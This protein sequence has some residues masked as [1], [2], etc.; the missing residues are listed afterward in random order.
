[1]AS[2]RDRALTPQAATRSRYEARCDTS[3]PSSAL[4]IVGWWLACGGSS[5]PS[6][7]TVDTVRDAAVVLSPNVVRVAVDR[8]GAVWA[9]GNRMGLT[10]R[11]ADGRV[12]H[13]TPRDGLP[14]AR[15]RSIAAAPDGS[16]W[17]STGYALA[18]YVPA[19]RRIVRPT[20]V[21]MPGSFAAVGNDAAG[22]VVLAVQ[23]YGVARVD[24][25][26]LL[27]I[28]GPEVLPPTN[29]WVAVV[30]DEP[31]TVWVATTG[32]G[33]WRSSAGWATEMP[34]VPVRSLALGPDG[35][36][37]I[38]T[39]GAGLWRAEPDADPAPVA[40]DRHLPR[41]LWDVAFDAAGGLWVASEWDGLRYVPDP[42]AAGPVHA[43]DP[44]LPVPDTL[45]LAHD[46]TTLWVGH[47]AGM[48]AVEEGAS[49]LVL[50][51][52]HGIGGNVM[53]LH[54]TP[55]GV[56]A[57]TAGG[58]LLA[59]N[60]HGIAQAGRREGVASNELWGVTT[61]RSETNHVLAWAASRFGASRAVRGRAHHVRVPLG[62]P[63]NPELYAIA[64]DPAHG[65]VW[66]ASR[67]QLHRV[68]TRTAA[69]R[70]L[71]DRC[72]LPSRPTAL[73]VGDEAL[74]VG[75]TGNERNLLEVPLAEPCA[76]S[77]HAV[78]GS[79]AR[80]VVDPD[81][82]VL[83]VTSSGLYH[84]RK[85]ARHAELRDERAR[86]VLDYDPSTGVVWT[87][88]KG[89]L[90]QLKWPS[91]QAHP[92]SLPTA[93]A[94]ST[95]AVAPT[96]VFVSLG[97]TIAWVRDQGHG[98]R[99]TMIRGNTE[100]PSVVAK[101]GPWMVQSRP[102]ALSLADLDRPGEGRV[103]PLPG[104]Q[105]TSLAP[106][107]DHTVLV[108]S[109]LSGLLVM[110]LDTGATW[111]PSRIAGTVRSTLRA[112]GAAWVAMDEGLYRFASIEPD[113][114]AAVLVDPR[115]WSALVEAA[116]G[117]I[118]TDAERVEA[119]DLDGH[120][121]GVVEP[122]QRGLMHR[123]TRWHL[124][125]APTRLVAE[126]AHPLPGWAG[127]RREV[128]LTTCGGSE[129]IAHDDHLVVASACG[130]S[131]VEATPPPWRWSDLL[132]G[133]AL[134]LLPL[135]AL[136]W[137]RRPDVDYRR[138]PESLRQLSGEAQFGILRGLA[139]RDELAAVLDGLGLPPSRR[140]QAEAL[141]G[142][143]SFG[144]DHLEVLSDLLEA[145][146]TARAEGEGGSGQRVE[147]TRPGGASLEIVLLALDQRRLVAETARGRAELIRSLTAP[148][149]LD[150]DD[151]HT[152]RLAVSQR[153]NRIRELW[154]DPA[155]G[156]LTRRHLGPLLLSA[157]PASS[158]AG[159][160]VRRG[161]ARHLSPYATTGAVKSADMFY[162][163]TDV[164]RTL[165]AGRHPTM[166]L[167]GPRRVGKSS[168]LAQL[169]RLREPRPGRVVRLHLQGIERIDDLTVLLERAGGSPLEA[170]ELEPLLLQWLEEGPLTLLLDEA[171]GLVAGPDGETLMALL[172]RTT[173]N[174]PL[175]VVLSGYL[176]LYLTALDRRGAA[177][178]F[179]DIVELGPLDAE[180]ALELAVEPLA[181][182]GMR[183]S[184]EAVAHTLVERAGRYPYVVQL[185]CDEALR[186]ATEDS[187]PVLDEGH[188]E[189]ACRSTRVR[190]DFAWFVFRSTPVLT[191]WIC[192]RFCQVEGLQRSELV[193]T[194]AAETAADPGAI[195]DAL[196]PLLLFGYLRR[197]D[198][199]EW[200]WCVPLFCDILAADAGRQRTLA[201]LVTQLATPT[202]PPNR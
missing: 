155:A 12:R 162:G 170:P 193:R 28:A 24:G 157:D 74:W 197:L 89:Q 200:A 64:H 110:D 57:A 85:G 38:P 41:E 4:V 53:D 27:R 198:Q 150:D 181:R 75:L 128:E 70:T 185:L 83:T 60:R 112:G 153:G 2:S 159:Q 61:V 19:E 84:L 13:F 10:R 158:L 14:G 132:P 50:D 161:V 11:E 69:V 23:G 169:H 3:K 137:W 164:L 115:P 187:G 174:H 44:G 56:L 109:A 113:T 34:V 167:V 7:H 98:T 165:L 119:F 146:V 6:V 131:W 124:R 135:A 186:A 8:S 123:G 168:V 152:A 121:Q 102:G 160:L 133:L 36:V 108:G 95:I 142:A 97:P 15:V 91:G 148:L 190:D 45:A 172:R 71:L 81:L 32:G 39:Q 35:A 88:T 145:R 107:D 58:G 101:V 20:G 63:P 129:L 96:G 141:V 195:D 76:W 86:S 175:A 111:S 68:D 196:R 51:T 154:P 136:R 79:L 116:G 149:A 90:L 100:V 87:A 199:D 80:V 191:Q 16:T 52:L 178:N 182:L 173:A 29:H 42:S 54:A 117:V 139:R 47:A 177:Y 65:A 33:V 122:P 151:V 5:A 144:A 82:G 22:N 92:V 77:A 49:R 143:G 94:P 194:V 93:A 183:W 192:L 55:T 166:L 67:R 103:W 66:L 140:R 21:P 30:V 26:E 18:R 78:P 163:R 62:P 40:F 126:R 106:W 171:D 156:M 114:A 134:L 17:L 127:P 105:V 184:S 59:I 48:S 9:V 120:P 188:L 104:R 176:E 118:A 1:M 180:S 202:A 138:D 25:D 73:A 179:A 147:L 31:G 189:R 99:I 37:W 125:D 72:E 201:D 46:G 43:P 130:T